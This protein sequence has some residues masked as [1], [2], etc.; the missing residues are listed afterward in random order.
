[1]I[2]LPVEE[3]SASLENKVFSNP[4]ISFTIVG[5]LLFQNPVISL[6]TA[7]GVPNPAYATQEEKI[8]EI[9]N[10]DEANDPPVRTHL[11]K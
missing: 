1:M 2:P 4:N 7:E 3:G 6:E 10:P 8:Y 11:I 5:G 9:S